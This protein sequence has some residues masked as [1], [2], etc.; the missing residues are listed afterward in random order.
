M[1]LDLDHF[2]IRV[3]DP[4]RARGFYVGVLGAVP[5]ELDRGRVG[6]RFGERQL[7]LHGPGSTPDPVA[8]TPAGPGSFDLCF[9]WPGTPEEAIAHLHS[10]AVEPE[11]GPV[12]RVGA[13][14]PG[15]SVYFRDP[16]GNLLELL[17]YA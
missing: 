16:D 11:L 5:V 7:N 3:S 2:V 1:K 8:A 6:L 13:R 15:T 9:V 17:S 4:E 14:G 12:P 10:F